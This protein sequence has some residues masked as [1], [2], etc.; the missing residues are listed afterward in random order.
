MAQPNH[1]E[2]FDDELELA[3]EVEWDR[4][5]DIADQKYQTWKERDL[6]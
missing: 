2:F 5:D 3:I 6:C 4:R 1:M